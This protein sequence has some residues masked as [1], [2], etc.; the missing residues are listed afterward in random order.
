[1]LIFQITLSLLLWTIISQI[2]AVIR[3][4]SSLNIIEGEGFIAYLEVP[5]SFGEIKNCWFKFRG[6]KKK[7]IKKINNQQ[8]INW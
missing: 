7:I 6:N 8:E 5:K 3:P 2:D 1:M 4:S